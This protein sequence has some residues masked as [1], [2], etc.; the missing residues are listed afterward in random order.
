MVM[1]DHS[2]SENG[3]KTSD[4]SKSM[5]AFDQTMRGLVKVPKAELDAE[6]RKYQRRKKA[7]RARRQA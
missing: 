4:S 1:E 7:R 3:K 5:K 6:E 2:N